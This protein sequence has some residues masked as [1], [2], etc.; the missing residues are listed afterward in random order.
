MSTETTNYKSASDF[1]NEAFNKI[2]DAPIASAATLR[3][4]GGL[5]M[6]KHLTSFLQ[7]WEDKISSGFAWAMIE[8]VD[9][10]N[11]QKVTTT[12][13]GLVQNIALLER[14]RLFGKT[15]DLDIR[16]NGRQ[17]HWRYVGNKT[18]VI[19]D[20][21]SFVAEDF[22]QATSNSNIKLREVTRSY[23]QWRGQDERINAHWYTT[24][25]LPEEGVRLQQKH[26][27][28]NGRLAFVR[29]VDLVE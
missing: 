2:K 25:D 26:Y 28:Q 23:Y 5:L 1:V 21:T 15:G 20:L 24:I 9:Q 10:F 13:E 29:Y 7:S 6:E 4:I 8:D 14:M 11:V 18:A 19:P 16:R 3:I 12:F 17:F 27:L 22:W